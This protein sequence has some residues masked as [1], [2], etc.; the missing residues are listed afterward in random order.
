MNQ[1]QCDATGEG[2]GKDQT[3]REKREK[4]GRE[5]EC[6]YWG[7]GLWRKPRNLNGG[8]E[9]GLDTAGWGVAKQGSTR[10]NKLKK[11]KKKNKGDYATKTTRSGKKREIFSASGNDQAVLL[12]RITVGSQEGSQEEYNESANEGGGR[13]RREGEQKE[14][15]SKK[16]S[17]KCVT[18]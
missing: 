15:V 10:T 8:I 18:P 17:G 14:A 3:N 1:G 12:H 9:Q 13:C 2:G 4:K 7:G 11:K 5:W 6:S 16:Q